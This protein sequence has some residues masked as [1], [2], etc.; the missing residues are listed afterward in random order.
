MEGVGYLRA[1]LDFN[2][3]VAAVSMVRAPTSGWGDLEG[4]LEGALEIDANIF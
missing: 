1:D 3:C 4:A 2:C